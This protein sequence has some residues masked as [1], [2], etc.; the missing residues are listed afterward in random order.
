MEGRASSFRAVFAD[1]ES[2]LHN[3]EYVAIDTELTGVDI[4]GESDRY[5]QNA[6]DRLDK[7]CRIAERYT[8]IELGLTLV[9]RKMGATA[10][11]E[12]YSCASYNLFAFPY[13]GP[14]LAGQEPG[15]YCQASALKFNAQHRL[16]FNHWIGEG[17]PFLSREAEKR[18]LHNGGSRDGT[19]DD[20]VG[21]LKL[22]KALCAA[23]LPFVVHTPL[24][25]FFL[26][27]A[28][29]RQP[30]PRDPRELSVVAAVHSEGIRHSSF[31]RCDWALRPIPRLQSQWPDTVS[32]GRAGE[33]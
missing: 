30:L 21:L 5:E 14:E 6:Q 31:A 13:I 18:Y 32:R 9:S 7:F 1:F 17:I 4:D 25:L 11:T 33:I 28:F 12:E 23:R 19:V 2:R 26:L 10:S 3:A 29:E 24:D 20:K 16:N 27:A 15:F 22:W 8:I